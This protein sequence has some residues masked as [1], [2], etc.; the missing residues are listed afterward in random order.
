MR[1]KRK[2]YKTYYEILCFIL[3]GC[4]VFSSLSSTILIRRLHFPMSMPELLLLPF[5]ILLKN[6]MRS[7]R[8]KLLDLVLISSIIGFLVIT[9]FVYDAY[10]LYS[11]LSSARSWFYLLLCL[12]AFSRSNRITNQDIAWVTFG[13]I[14]GWAIDSSLNFE[15]LITSINLGRDFLCT[16]GV[17]LAIPFFFSSVMYNNKYILLSIGLGLMFYIAIYSGIRR[18]LAILAFSLIGSILLSL[19]KSGKKIFSY[20]IVAVIAFAVISSILPSIRDS[21]EE[22]SFGLYHR[23]FLRTE[24]MFEEEELISSDQGRLA[25]IKNVLNNMLDYT[26]S[27]GMVSVRTSEDSSVGVFNDFPLYQLFWIFSWPVTLIILIQAIRITIR[28][29]K[30]FII[31]KD[32]TSMI[33]LNCLFIIFV[34]LFLDGTFLEYPYATPITGMLLGRAILNARNVDIIE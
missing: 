22:A 18:P 11:M 10:P 23:T 12:F 27:R 32:E 4:L 25:T 16:Y 24:Q 28:N 15:R 8:I 19:K 13:C 26:F 17:Y 20:V 7:I 5:F 33:S 34:L 30:K 9:G 2:I 21:L 29:Y 1:K 14:I 6:K 31:Y 3:M